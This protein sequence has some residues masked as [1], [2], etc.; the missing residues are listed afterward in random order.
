MTAFGP[1]AIAND[2]LE[3]P[4]HLRALLAQRG[5]VFLR[6]LIEEPRTERALRDGILAAKRFGLIDRR[7][8]TEPVWSGIQLRGDEFA[9]DCVHRQLPSKER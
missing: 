6:G 5:Y 9:L 7:A 4:P 2:A 8:T 1:L 3:D